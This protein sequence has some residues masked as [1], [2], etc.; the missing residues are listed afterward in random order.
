MHNVLLSIS[1]IGDIFGIALVAIAAL[2]LKKIA[3]THSK[4]SDVNS[5]P[6]NDRVNYRKYS[7]VLIVGVSTAIIATILNLVSLFV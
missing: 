4:A 1:I 5:L 6:E 7:V 2:K 3:K